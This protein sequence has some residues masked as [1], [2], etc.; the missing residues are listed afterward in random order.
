MLS[1]SWEKAKKKAKDEGKDEPPRSLIK[2]ADLNDKQ[3]PDWDHPDDV[4]GTP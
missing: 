3:N 4:L 1:I 2:D